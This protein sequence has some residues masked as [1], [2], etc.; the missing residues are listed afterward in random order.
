MKVS[1]FSSASEKAVVYSHIAKDIAALKESIRV[2]RVQHN[3]LNIT[4]RLPDELMERIFFWNFLMQRKS[5]KNYWIRVAGVCTEWR[6]VALCCPQL[7]TVVRSCRRKRWVTEV[8]STDSRARAQNLLDTLTKAAPILEYLKADMNTDFENIH[9]LPEGLFDHTAPKLRKLVLR[10]C[11]IPSSSPILPG[12]TTLTLKC[13]FGGLTLSQLIDLLQAARNIKKLELCRP[14]SFNEDDRQLRR[15]S[16]SSK[17]HVVLHHLNHLT[18]IEEGVECA[19]LLSS[20]SCPSATHIQVQPRL[21]RGR[22]FDAVP[23]LQEELAT[24]ISPVNR[25]TI[26]NITGMERSI[27]LLHSKRGKRNDNQVPSDLTLE[28]EMHDNTLWMLKSLIHTFALIDLQCLEMKSWVPPDFLLGEFGDLPSLHTVDVKLRPSAMIRALMRDVSQQEAQDWFDNIP[29]KSAKVSA[30]TQRID[31]H[32][33]QSSERSEALE[34]SGASDGDAED[35]SDTSQSES[36]WH[37]KS[38]MTPPRRFS[39]FKDETKLSAVP[40]TPGARSFKAL[41]TLKF[42]DDCYFDDI[43]TTFLAIALHVR[44][45]RHSP[46]HELSVKQSTHSSLTADRDVD[47]MRRSVSLLQWDV[48][49]LEDDVEG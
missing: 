10:N 12:I 19:I 7:W 48:E 30:S 17:R 4:A 32:Q 15:S 45:T 47:S 34:Q 2:L 33:E 43:D 13:L 23:E 5:E 28:I 41:K 1:S 44:H 31:E 22:G 20:I 8:K 9:H 3:L 35:G 25:L 49:H 39:H 18:I 24:C 11:S 16:S 37:R 21:P 26:M 14:C 42:D 6:R 27:L 29:I 46:L 36:S 38:R 40:T